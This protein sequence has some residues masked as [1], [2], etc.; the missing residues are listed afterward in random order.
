MPELKIKVLTDR[1]YMPE[2][3]M[4]TDEWFDNNTSNLESKLSINP[5]NNRKINFSKLSSKKNSLAF[6][7]SLSLFT[8]EPS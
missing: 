3:N 7:K 8:T 5:K 6:K 1:I 4:T 2:F